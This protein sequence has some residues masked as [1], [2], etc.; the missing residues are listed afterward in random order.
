MAFLEF[1]PAP[2]GAGIVSTWLT[3]MRIAAIERRFPG[4]RRGTNLKN[5]QV[6]VFR[7]YLFRG[8][9]QLNLPGTSR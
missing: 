2:A 5:E 3:H 6:S 4:S 7:R 9:S 8:E 1:L